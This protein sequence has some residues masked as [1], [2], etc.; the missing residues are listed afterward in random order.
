MQQARRDSTASESAATPAMTVRER[1]PNTCEGKMESKD[2][3]LSV[4]DGA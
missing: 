2:S 1:A 4:N 3:K